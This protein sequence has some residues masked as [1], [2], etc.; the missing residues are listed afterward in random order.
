MELT[1]GLNRDSKTVLVRIEAW[2][3]VKLATGL[4]L[5]YCRRGRGPGDDMLFLQRGRLSNTRKLPPLPS[6]ARRAEALA[7][8]E[9]YVRVS[10]S[11]SRSAC[12]TGQRTRLA[13]HQRTLARHEAQAQSYAEKPSLDS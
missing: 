1:T 12:R 9:G 6:T 11:S 10:G 3:F 13:G 2:S 8:D 7:A 5:N 4:E